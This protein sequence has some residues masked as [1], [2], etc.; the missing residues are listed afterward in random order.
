[1]IRTHCLLKALATKMTDNDSL[2]E[3]LRGCADSTVFYEC[4]E[5]GK[6]MATDADSEDVCCHNNGCYFGETT[7]D[8]FAPT[9]TL[10]NRL[11]YH[12]KPFQPAI[13]VDG[14]HE[15]V[16]EKGR[17]Y[18]MGCGLCCDECGKQIPPTE[19]KDAMSCHHCH[20]LDFTSFNPGF[21]ICRVCVTKYPP[22]PAGDDGTRTLWLDVR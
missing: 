4:G 12:K 9:E 11:S 2:F 16:M 19:Y 20:Y 1:M 22:I 21:D 3:V 17:A 10:D 14:W 7:V 18:P 5:C 8:R 15:H 13:M 6:W